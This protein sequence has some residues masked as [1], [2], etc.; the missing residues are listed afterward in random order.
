MGRPKGY[1]LNPRALD[2]TIRQTP[3]MTKAKLLKIIDGSSGMLAD[4]ENRWTGVSAVYVERIA[5]ALAVEPE[6]L[7][8]ELSGRFDAKP[9]PVVPQVA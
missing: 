9:K 6:V 4:A 8:P 1:T 2:F 3:G 7:F 5:T